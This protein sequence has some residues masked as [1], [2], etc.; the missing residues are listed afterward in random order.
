MRTNR[1]AASG[2]RLFRTTVHAC[3]PI[4]AIQRAMVPKLGSIRPPL[5]LA[6]TRQRPT[7]PTRVR[8]LPVGCP[9]GA[10]SAPSRGLFPA[11]TRPSI[12]VPL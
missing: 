1:S 3:R 8:W 9:C 11:G 2:G 7:A 4:A 12:A 5:P 10:H 6:P